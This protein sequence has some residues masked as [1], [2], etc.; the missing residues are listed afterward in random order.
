M[1][2]WAGN[3][4]YHARAIHRPRSIDELR[5]L[6]RSSRRVRALGTR[7][8]FNGL[9]DT[10]ADLVSLRDVPRVVAVDPQ[11]GT[12]TIDGGATYTDVT[13]ALDSAGFALP[14]L[15]SLPHISVA[16][17]VATATGRSRTTS[18]RKSSGRW[19][20][21][22]LAS[23]AMPQAASAVSARMPGQPSPNSFAP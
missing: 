22:I 11:R 23:A 9:A 12:V 20:T 4:A 10:D 3:L 7:H 6:V 16:G 1:R 2:N 17:A 13:A 14:N 8:A 21:R 18:T 15:A 5:S 19:P